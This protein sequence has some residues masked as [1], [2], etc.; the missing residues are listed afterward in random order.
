MGRKDGKEN[1]GR[2]AHVRNYKTNGAPLHAGGKVTD[3]QQHVPTFLTTTDLTFGIRVVEF[4]PLVV[5]SSFAKKL[6]RASEEEV[7]KGAQGIPCTGSGAVR[8]DIMKTRSQETVVRSQKVKNAASGTLTAATGTVAVPE[9]WEGGAPEVGKGGSKARFFST[10][11]AFFPGSSHDF[12]AF[13]AFSHLIFILWP[14]GARIHRRDPE[15]QRVE[16]NALR[17]VAATQPRS[18][19]APRIYV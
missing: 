12:P 2:E 17:L 11:M 14:S 18:G 1:N 9:R 10:R 13:P 8:M 19:E 3:A 5:G 16:A 7:Q 4:G 6:W 15:V